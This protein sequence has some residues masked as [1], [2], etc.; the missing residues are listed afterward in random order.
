VAGSDGQDFES[1]TWLHRAQVLPKEQFKQEVEKHWDAMAGGA[2]SAGR[3]RRLEY[4]TSVSVAV[5]AQTQ[6]R[7]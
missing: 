4:T 6:V 2:N 3:C 1:A 5:E 7:T